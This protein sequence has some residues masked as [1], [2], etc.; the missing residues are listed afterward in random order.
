MAGFA[1]YA[2]ENTDTGDTAGGDTPASDAAAAEPTATPKPTEKPEAEVTVPDPSEDFY[3]LDSAA[4]LTEKT[5]GDILANSKALDEKYGIQIVV[6][7]IKTRGQAALE[8]YCYQLFNKWKIGGE[9]GNGLLFLLDIDDDTYTAMAGAGIKAEFT[10]DVLNNMVKTKLEDSF[11]AK[12][13]DV[14]VANLFAEAVTQSTAYGEKNGLTPSAGNTEKNKGS[15][16]LSVIITVVIIIV[17]L[18]VVFFIVVYLRGQ[19]LRKKRLAR[20]AAGR[21]VSTYNRPI[22]R[23][24]YY[25]T[26]SKYDFDG[27]SSR[28]KNAPRRTRGRK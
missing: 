1:V 11:S 13:Y 16:V 25:S 23:E 5:K 9:K 24:S 6:V 27:F 3:V 28:Q 2:D 17:L 4:V 10:A 19:A 22:S 26:S 18:I 7:T 14:G 21:N 15:S 20:R 12:N 8:D